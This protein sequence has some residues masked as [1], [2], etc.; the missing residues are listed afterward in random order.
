MSEP[1]AVA[2]APAAFAEDRPVLACRDLARTFDVLWWLVRLCEW[3]L[4]YE[5][6]QLRGRGQ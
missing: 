3:S 2:A 5:L 6:E 4:V 1:A